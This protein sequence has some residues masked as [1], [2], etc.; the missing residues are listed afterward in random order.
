MTKENDT[1]TPDGFDRIPDRYSKHSRETIDR[2]RDRC[3]DITE[4][5]SLYLKQI[6]HS[7]N[8]IADFVF[9]LHCFLTAMKYEDRIGL[10]DEEERDKKKMQWYLQMKEHVLIP[11]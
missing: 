3:H 7:P 5:M 9:A 4:E 1:D 10:K 2:M 11:E 8:D 6:V